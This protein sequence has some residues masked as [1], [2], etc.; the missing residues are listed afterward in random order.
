MQQSYR[1]I[2]SHCRHLVLDSQNRGYI[3][4]CSWLLDARPPGSVVVEGSGDRIAQLT[5]KVVGI[6]LEVS[7]E[8]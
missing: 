3:G 1:T 7:F 2:L 6:R 5:R 4:L 8:E